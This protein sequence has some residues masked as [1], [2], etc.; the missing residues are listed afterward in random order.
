[1][2]NRY[3]DSSRPPV[4]GIHVLAARPREDVDGRVN[5]AMTV[6]RAAA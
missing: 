2:A 5:P 1:M 6:E 3:L 4:A